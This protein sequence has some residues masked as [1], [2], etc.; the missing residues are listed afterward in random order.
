MNLT[1]GQLYFINEQDIKTNARSNYYKIGIVRD[2][3]N[4]DSHDRL[5]EH[6][7]GNPRKLL[8]VETLK[9]PAVEAVE[10]TLHYLFARNRVMGEWMFFTE[11]E[12]ANAIEKAKELAGVM[13]SNIKNFQK[14][15][16]LK[17]IESNGTIIDSS[18]EA[19]EHY[20]TLM[21]FKEVLVSCK[22]VLDEY[23]AYLKKAVEI[24]VSVEGKATI[25]DRTGAKV[26]N[27]AL[28]LEKYPEL[29]KQ[30]SSVNR[31]IKGKFSV[32]ADSSWVFDVSTLDSDQVDLIANLKQQLAT[33]DYSMEYG[34]AL[35]SQ[36]LGVL[37][38]KKY[39]EW[40][41]NIANINLRVLTG[42]ADG[43]KDICT[44]KRKIKENIVLDKKQ[45]QNNHPLEYS[46]CVVQR[47]NS[48]A[49]RV[50]PNI[51]QAQ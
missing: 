16:E 33:P 32:K 41:S 29:Y 34:F 21:N 2:A 28:F 35:H 17:N 14:S 22:D 26:F 50:N 38:I 37:E 51:A 1:S 31:E 30:Y 27:E 10:T 46:E 48:Q 24:G 39:A 3:D 19:E 49:M 36:Y 13:D 11:S 4:R 47:A 25:Q 40:E 12:L 7:T 43:I 45:I 9:M 20:A 42:E 44:W 6:Q 5:L 8:I 15:E 23:N 18:D